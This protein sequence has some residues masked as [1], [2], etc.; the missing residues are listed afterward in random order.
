MYIKKIL[1]KAKIFKIQIIISILCA[2][3]VVITLFHCMTHAVRATF[4][5][6][7]ISFGNLRG[8]LVHLHFHFTSQY[9]TFKSISIVF[10]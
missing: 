3:A 1:G 6:I 9:F 8:L 5:N 2:F 10:S 7:Y 4:A